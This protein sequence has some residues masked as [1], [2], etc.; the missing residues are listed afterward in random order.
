MATQNDIGKTG[1]IIIVLI[2]QALYHHQD[3]EQTDQ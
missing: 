1:T 3:T 2:C